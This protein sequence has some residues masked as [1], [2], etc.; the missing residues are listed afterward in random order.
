MEQSSFLELLS[1]DSA[2]PCYF[3]ELQSYKLLF[4]NRALEKGLKTAQHYQ[5]ELCYQMIFQQD[6]PCE[7]CPMDQVEQ[8]AFQEKHIFHPGFQSHYRANSTLLE[9]QGQK[10]L[11]CKCFLAQSK[12]SQGQEEPFEEENEDLQSDYSS[13]AEPPSPPSAFPQ[14]QEEDSPAAFQDHPEEDQD[15]L[16]GFFQRS[17]Y[18]EKVL[19]LEQHP[20]K[21]LGVL[22]ANLNGLR[23]TNEFFGFEVGDLQIKKTAQTLC[24][25]FPQEFYRISGDEFLC[26]VPDAG[27]VEFA[28]QVELLRDHLKETNNTSFAVGHTWAS[29]GYIDVAKLVADADTVMYINKQDYYFTSQKESTEICDSILQDLFQAIENQEFMVYLQP[30]VNLNTGEMTG[31]EA[32]IRRYDRRS[33]KMIYPDSFI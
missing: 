26:F 33:E 23:K 27:E 2:N 15:P 9:C 31:A 25:F 17:R 29:G 30:K 32:L 19:D 6:S 13:P 1:N 16:T 5:G 7:D 3:A 10:I 18:Q 21:S 22:F 11:F 4:V 12:A 14:C 24:K 28:S 20:P 8:G